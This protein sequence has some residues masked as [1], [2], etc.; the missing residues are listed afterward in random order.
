MLFTR[1]HEREVEIDE[2]KIAYEQEIANVVQVK[3]GLYCA[4]KVMGC[5]AHSQS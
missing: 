4:Y 1:N 2:L 3:C 5:V